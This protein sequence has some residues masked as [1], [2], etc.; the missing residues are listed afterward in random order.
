MPANATI[1]LRSNNV[2]LS[3]LFADVTSDK[4]IFKRRTFFDV[5]LGDDTVRFNVMDPAEIEFHLHGF[6]GYISTLNQGEERKTD[7]IYLIRQTKAVL[8]L[9]TDKEF[10][11]NEAIWPSLFKI[12]GAYDGFVFVFD[13]VLLSNGAAL[14]G[15]LVKNYARFSP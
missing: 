1:Y 2:N 14:V 6:L 15:P 5:R 8:G 12:A 11:E 9:V 10:R 4:S 3:S 7:A 13:S